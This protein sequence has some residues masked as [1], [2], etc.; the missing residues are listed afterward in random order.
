M[1]GGSAVHLIVFQP[2]SCADGQDFQCG[3]EINGLS[4]KYGRTVMG[5]DAIQSVLIA[6]KIAAADLSSSDEYKSR[7]LYW[8]EVGD[9]DIGL[10]MKA[11]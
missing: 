1:I 4:K 6:L 2:S 5:V 10:P 9:T 7:D 8:L 3:Y 11:I